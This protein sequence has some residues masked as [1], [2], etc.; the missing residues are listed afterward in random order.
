MYYNPN[1]I[2]NRL[3]QALGM[4]FYEVCHYIAEANVNLKDEEI[5]KY[6]GNKYLKDKPGAREKLLLLKKKLKEGT[7]HKV[8]DFLEGYTF[9]GDIDRYRF[10]PQT[11][12]YFKNYIS[13]LKIKCNNLIKIIDGIIEKKIPKEVLESLD[14]NL[15]D[16]GQ[17]LMSD[18]DRLIDPFI[19]NFNKLRDMVERANN[20]DT[21]FDFKISLDLMR[22]EA[23]YEAELYP[24]ETLQ[25]S[26]YEIEGEK[27]FIP[28]TKRQ[29]LALRREEKRIVSSICDTFK[30][31][32]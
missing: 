17:I 18:I 28:Y 19:F 22:H 31:L 23:A 27:G 4:N 2:I 1:V 7:R 29:K 16:H 21:Y 26:N 24:R 12:V 8:E 5:S 25:N 20:L 9:N 11:I 3:E 15:D 32:K 30:N 10:E 14:I 6:L 13:V